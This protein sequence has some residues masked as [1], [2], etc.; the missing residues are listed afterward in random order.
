M[1]NKYSEKEIIQYF[2]VQNFYLQI[3]DFM[4]MKQQNE[5]EKIKLVHTLFVLLRMPTQF[6]NV[7][8]KLFLFVWKCLIK[9]SKKGLKTSFLCVCVLLLLQ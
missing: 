8:L 6:Q 1:R 3:L 9:Y 7:D 4:N 5:T 2:F